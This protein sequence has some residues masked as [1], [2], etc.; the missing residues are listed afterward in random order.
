[1]HITDLALCS[2]FKTV[3]D[4]GDSYLSLSHSSLS[5]LQSMVNHELLKST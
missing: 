1:M 2:K 4:A 5:S 3:L